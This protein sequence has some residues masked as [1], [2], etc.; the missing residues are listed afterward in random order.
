MLVVVKI[1]AELVLRRSNLIVF[2]FCKD[3]QF[4]ELF[5]KIMHEVRDP[6]LQRAEVVVIQFLPLGRLC[7]EK[8]A[9]AVDQVTTLLIQFLVDEEIFLLGDRRWC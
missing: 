5:V 6:I 8:G 1:G 4:P 9:A 7:T 2:G 3:A